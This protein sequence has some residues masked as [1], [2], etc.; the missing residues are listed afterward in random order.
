M[1]SQAFLGVLILAYQSSK[2]VE[3]INRKS[4]TY[5]F[6]L[7]AALSK[8]K[9]SSP[10]SSLLLTGQVSVSVVL[11]YLG[12]RPVAAFPFGEFDPQ[13]GR[14]PLLLGA[15]YGQHAFV[16]C[17]RC[18]QMAKLNMLSKSYKRDAGGQTGQ[19]L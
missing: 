16:S 12:L 9:T 19:R 4:Y 6:R 18:P 3:L 14:N 11:Q 5:S 10:A 7:R 13:A 15:I 17:H 1:F 8:V 2:S